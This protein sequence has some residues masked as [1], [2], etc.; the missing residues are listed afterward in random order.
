MGERGEDETATLSF[1]RVRKNLK[2][3]TSREIRGKVKGLL[4]G[5]NLFVAM[6]GRGPA[7]CG[8]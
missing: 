7:L 6:G 2:E 5:A 8:K 4:M 3:G 1:R